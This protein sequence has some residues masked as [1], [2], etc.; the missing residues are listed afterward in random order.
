[1]KT[2]LIHVDDENFCRVL[3]QALNG[4]APGNG[5]VKV[6]FSSIAC[7]SAPSAPGWLL[8]AFGRHMK[9][10]DLLK[11]RASPFR[12]RTLTRRTELPARMLEPGLVQPDAQTEVGA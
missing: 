10:T 3:P 5:R 7:S 4:S 12:R 8:R 1:M 2:F 11:L 9:T 6:C